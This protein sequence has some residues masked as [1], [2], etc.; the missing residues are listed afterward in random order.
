MVKFTCPRFTPCLL[1]TAA[2]MAD[3]CLRQTLRSTCDSKLKEGLVQ[4][5][6]ADKWLS[7]CYH[8]YTWKEEEASLTCR[9]LGFKG[10]WPYGIEN[11]NTNG[12][13]SEHGYLAR[14]DCDQSKCFHFRFNVNM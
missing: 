4:V 10:G 12:T 1:F 2:D 14:L 11:V 3:I 5:R 8:K 6:Q 13:N 7:I 9:Q